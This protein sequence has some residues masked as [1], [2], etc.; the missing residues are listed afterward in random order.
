MRLY[1]I[2]MKRYSNMYTYVYTHAREHIHI[3]THGFAH[4]NIYTSNNHSH[5]LA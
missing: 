2:I 1:V 4:K 5:I 3:R